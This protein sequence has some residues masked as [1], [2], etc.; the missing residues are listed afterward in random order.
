[1]TSFGLLDP[2][3]LWGSAIANFALIMAFLAVA[4]VVRRAGWGD[5][6]ALTLLFAL[7]GAAFLGNA[8]DLA[9]S[10]FVVIGKLACAA[11]AAFGLLRIAFSRWPAGTTTREATSADRQG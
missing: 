8:D 3:L 6:W 9:L 11:F 4:I 1:M 7:L 5:G 2:V 10:Q